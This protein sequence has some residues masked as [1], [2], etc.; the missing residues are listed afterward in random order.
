MQVSLKLPSLHRVGPQYQ[1]RQTRVSE[2]EKSLL[3]HPLGLYPH[4]EEAIPPEVSYWHKPISC[5]IEV[6][7]LQV[8][9]EVVCVLDPELNPADSCSEV[10]HIRSAFI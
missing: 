6:I 2:V 4:L 9:E 3:K 1:E 5:I 7:F 8:L 10:D